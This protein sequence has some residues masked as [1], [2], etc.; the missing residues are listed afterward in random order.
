MVEDDRSGPPFPLVFA[1]PMLL[2]SRQ[3]TTWRRSDYLAWLAAAGFEDISVK[4]TPTPS[5]MIFAR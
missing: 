1:S 2:Q 3:G 4:P 5:T